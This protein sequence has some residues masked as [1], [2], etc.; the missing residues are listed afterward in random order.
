LISRNIPTIAVV[1]SNDLSPF[2]ASY[3]KGANIVVGNVQNE[4]EI[5]TIVEEFLPTVS[6]CCL[7]SRSGIKRDSW[8]IDYLGGLNV[9]NAFSQHSK[10]TCPHFVLLSAFCVGKPRL[11]FQKAKLKLEAAI[12]A[13][14]RVS[15]SIVRPTAFFKS[16]DGQ[17]ESV[18][19]GT[20]VLYFGDG[21]CSANAI[22]AGDLA[23]FM[24]D[25]AFDSSLLM[26]STLAVGG[27]GF[28]IF[29]RFLF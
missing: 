25:C 3:L 1:R 20:P 11:Q 27:P 4:K 18:R 6:I 14:D 10:A 24:C 15:H 29:L 21:T 13:N 17:I 22:C 2:T 8:D 28:T 19:K 9:L 12:R 23:K 26:N 7:A 16:I 5:G